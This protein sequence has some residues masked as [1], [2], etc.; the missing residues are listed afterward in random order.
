MVV[1]NA[2]LIHELVLR[3]LGIGLMPDIMCRDDLARG[4]LVRIDLDW[5]SPPLLA[6]ATFLARRH[7]PAK[8]RAFLDHLAAFRSLLI[9]PLPVC[10]SRVT[11]W[12]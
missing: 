11:K 4:A 9:L 6:S 7:M 12:V 2:I 3:G 1:N 10:M 8:T 5:A